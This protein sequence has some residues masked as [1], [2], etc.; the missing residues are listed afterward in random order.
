MVANSP[1]SQTKAAA[2]ALLPYQVRWVRDTSPVAIWEKSRRVGADFVEAFRVVHERMTG[3]RNLDYWYSS[4]DESAAVEFM[5]Y[6]KRFLDLYKV[7]LEFLEH[8]EILDGKKFKVMSVELPRVGD[9]C[10]RITVMTSSPKRFRSKGGD[11][12][13]SEYAFHEDAE[14]LW[15]AV[16]AVT[17]WGGRLRVFSSHNDESSHFNRLIGQAS[18]P[19]DARR[20]TDLVAS[21]HRTTIFDAVEDGL[22]ER[23]N[24][25]SGTDYTR[26]GFIAE[27][28]A[29]AGSEEAWLREYCCVP[30]RQAMSFLPMSLYAPC[31][32]ADCPLPTGDLAK[33][34]DAVRERAAAVGAERIIAGCDVGR[35]HDRF[36]IWVNGRVGSARRTL[37][38]FVA[39]GIDFA[40]MET[41][42]V[43]TMTA[44]GL[45]VRRL[46]IDATGLGMQLAERMKRQFRGRVEGVTMTGT[47][48]ED[49]FTTLRAALDERSVTLPD[50]PECI[51]DF[52]SVRRE[53]TS[54]GNTRYSAKSNEHGHADRATACAL[55]LHADETKFA[56]AR[57]VQTTGVW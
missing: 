5:V 4:A 32:D 35:V 8:D 15:G 13:L 34:I 38:A 14:A 6:V 33:F 57:A 40:Q 23:I 12:G 3:Q 28:K 16:F 29:K 21:L 1:K 36:V 7:G 48:K 55:A 42:I 39:Q 10:P 9:R 52:G 51:M 30:S 17:T 54:A 27:Q 31:I 50:C 25:V 43:V 20:P 46:C 11:V 45:K 53:I 44:P 37:G 18:K 22:V 26:A 24:A 2:P 41:A 47:F 56:T 19:A 49:L